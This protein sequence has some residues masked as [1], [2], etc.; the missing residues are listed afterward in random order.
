VPKVIEDS[1]FA[2]RTWFTLEGD[3][4][5]GSFGMSLRVSS[6]SV[7]LVGTQLKREGKKTLVSEG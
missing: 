3:F 2:I 1:L 6:L 4:H 7:G 5:N